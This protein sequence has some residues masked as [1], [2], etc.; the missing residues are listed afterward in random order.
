MKLVPV[1]LMLAVALAP[2]A[3][4]AEPALAAPDEGDEALLCGGLVCEILCKINRILQRPCLR[5]G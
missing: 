2:V 3:L 5:A 4:A 1:V